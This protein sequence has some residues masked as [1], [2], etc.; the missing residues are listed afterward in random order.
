[1]SED[2]KIF[3]RKILDSIAYQGDAEVFVHE[4]VRTVSME[5]FSVIIE[6]M[7]EPERVLFFERVSRG[8]IGDF[9]QTVLQSV[10]REKIQTTFDL[11]AQHAL[12]QY[13][14]VIVPT[15]SS[16]Q[17]KALAILFNALT[18]PSKT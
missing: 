18:S 3:L 17:R 9:E 6:G 7:S 10:S 2:L 4:F 15:L 5:A 8:K 12:K 16:E 14:Y 1:M 11:C 13:L